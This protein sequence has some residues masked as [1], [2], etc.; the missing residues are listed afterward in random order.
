MN[1]DSI[2]PLIA[3]T[4]SSFSPEEFHHAVNVTFHN[5]EAESY[6]TLHAGMWESLFEQIDLLSSDAMGA[7]NTGDNLKM[8]DVGCGTGLSSQLLLRTKLGNT[9]SDV[10][11]LDTS[12]NML[13]QAE[14]KSRSWGKKVECINDSIDGVEGVFDIIIISSVLH[15]IPDL[16]SF[17]S[18]VSDL[19][20][21]GGILI[22]LQDPNG[23]YFNDPEYIE[24]TRILSGLNRQDSNESASI[25]NTV[26]KI[27]RPLFGKKSY[28]DRVNDD[29]IRQKVIKRRMTSEEIWSVTD[30]HVENLPFSIGKGISMQNVKTMLEQYRLASQRSYAFFGDLKSDL[31]AELQETEAALIKSRAL[32]G[33]NVSAVWIRE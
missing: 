26:K 4:Q 22:H 27:L 31:P 24:R 20:K 15:H 8:L 16:N 9:V 12:Q 29:L 17:F 2:L 13:A 7:T 11:L 6:D 1:L 23:D 33:R 3:K 21:A 19:Q 32:N 14:L 18:K 30:I 25:L 5:I 28:I 10:T